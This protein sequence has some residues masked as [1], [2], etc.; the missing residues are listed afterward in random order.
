MCPSLKREFLDLITIDEAQKI[1]KQ[2][3]TWNP[4]FEVIPLNSSK[5]RIIAE[6]IAAKIDSPPFDRSLMD[7]FAVRAEDTFDIDETHSKKFKII[8]S[9][10]AGKVSNTSLAC[11]FT[12]IEISTGA[13]IPQGANAVAMVEY[14]SKVS[15][16][17]VTIFRSVTPHENIDPA[18]SDIMYGE[19]LLR[20]G[21][22]LDS[23]RLGI[24]ASLGVSSVKVLSKIKVGIL[25]S[26]N[27]LRRPGEHLPIGCLYD[28]NSIVLS[29]LTEESG[30]FPVYLGICPDDLEILKET[31]L[32]HIEHIDIFLISGGTSAGEG[33]FSYRIIRELGG[34]LLFHGVSMKP[35]KPL[36]VG[37]IK[38]KLF[39]TVPGFPASAIFS[40][41][42]VIAPLF[43][44]WTRTSVPPGKTIEA[45]INQKLRSTLG[46]TQFKL[47]HVMKKGNSFT[48]YPVKGTSGS[49][50]M[51]E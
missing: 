42:T 45:V 22:I 50:S 49:M 9:V 17:E 43:R 47:V 28:S 36:A 23:V 34:K 25:S 33:D 1:I 6:N 20:N 41:S 21:D 38:D 10:P 40:F 19:T 13:P 35:G 51:L 4:S 48:A 18:G 5:G 8:D 16:K 29:M 14:S 27:E 7:G 37:L 30:A 3:Y 26:G 2:N 11:P 39:F 31:I 12:C 44:E 15:D 24:L 46:R 32:S